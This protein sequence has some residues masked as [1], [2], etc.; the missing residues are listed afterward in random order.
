M[1]GGAALVFDHA[2]PLILSPRL[3]QI[4]AIIGKRDDAF[5]RH[6]P[7]VAAD[8]GIAGV[9]DGTGAFVQAAGADVERA[10]LDSATQT[11]GGMAGRSA[12]REAA[13]DK[14]LFAA[15]PRDGVCRA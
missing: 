5:P 11:L 8:E 14:E 7:R 13:D 15:P 12:V 1:D 6:R 9:A 2:D 4:Q 10:A 3:R